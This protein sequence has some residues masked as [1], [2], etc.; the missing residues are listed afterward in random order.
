M[1]SA[2]P[3]NILALL[4]DPNV[5]SQQ[6]AEA[7]GAPREDAVRAARLVMGIAKAQPEEASSLPGSLAAAVARAA[8]QGGRA[9]ILVALAVHPSREAAKEAKRGLHILKSRGVAVPQPQRP[10]PARTSSATPEPSFPCYASGMDG[11]GER[12]VWIARA[13]PGRGVEVGQAVISDVLGLLELQMALLG[14]KEYRAFGQDIED[15]GRTMGVAEIPRERAKSLVAAARRLNEISGRRLPEGAEAWLGRLGPAAPLGD[16]ARDFPP[17]PE[18]E[19]RAALL[20]SARLHGL[21]MMRGWLAEEGF[22]RE[23]AHKL[24]E[25]AVSPLYLDEHQRAEQAAQVI[26]DAV[27]SYLD[28]PRR[29]RLAG[30]LFATAAQLVALGDVQ[31][32]RL[33]AAAARAVA[34]GVAGSQI[35]FARLLVEKAFPPLSNLPAP[36]VPGAENS[37]IVTPR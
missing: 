16:P 4:K 24:D 5:D 35:P 9:D 20:A 37:L 7:T 3:G 13:A 25:I 19:E 12:A 8:L 27:E 2:D 36:D 6:V 26:G 15:K 33:S 11:E 14:R 18:A 32:A 17:L 23:L 30:R 21:P 22:L 10:N 29:H 34:A 31:N 28:E 1:S